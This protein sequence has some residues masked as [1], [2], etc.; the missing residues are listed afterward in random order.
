VQYVVSGKEILFEYHIVNHHF[1]FVNAPLYDKI[2]SLARNAGIHPFTRIIC[3]HNS[4]LGFQN[5]SRKEGKVK[6]LENKKRSSANVIMK[7]YLSIPISLA[8]LR[9]QN[10]SICLRLKQL[11]YH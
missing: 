1:S 11:N 2:N 6:D 10:L 8:L 3:S 5:S 4:D 9:L 7:Y